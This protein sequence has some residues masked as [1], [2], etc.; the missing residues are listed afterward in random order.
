[1]LKAISR[2][3]FK[4]KIIFIFVN[5]FLFFLQSNEEEE[6]Q[7][8]KEDQKYINEFSRLHSKNKI[9]DADIK[10]AIQVLESLDDCI[11]AIDESFGATLK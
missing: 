1:M 4:I 8:T 3:Y 6:P 10:K 5:L 9:I 11:S 2:V 7:V